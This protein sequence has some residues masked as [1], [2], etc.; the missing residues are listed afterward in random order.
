[1]KQDKFKN[2]LLIVL[3]SAFVYK[4][5]I[6]LNILNDNTPDSLTTTSK[7]ILFETNTI[8][9][10][11]HPSCK[12]C[13]NAMKFIDTINQPNLKKIYINTNTPSG[14]T[15]YKKAIVL[16]KESN[17]TIGVPI[18][19]YE[20]NILVGFDSQETTGQK[21]LGWINNPSK[22]NKNTTQSNKKI[23]SEQSNSIQASKPK[24]ELNFKQQTKRVE[25]PLIG[26]I[27]IDNISLPLLAILLGLADGF[28][29]CAMWVLIYLIS[30]MPG[31]NNRRKMIYI[32]GTFI[33]ASG[34]LYFL[35]MTAWLNIFLFIGYTKILS[36]LIAL[37]AIWFGCNN[38]Y[39]LI[40]N[41]G[42]A[43]CKVDDFYSKQKSKNKINNIVN[44]PVS[45][46]TF[47][48]LIGLAFTVNAIE[49]VCSSGLPAIFTH[50]L[51]LNNLSLIT[52][53]LYI[54]LYIFAFI[55]DDIIVFGFAIFAVNKILDT[56]YAS[57]CKA[58]GGLI[59]IL[60]G[61]W[62]LFTQ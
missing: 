54:L 34:I 28:N 13:N 12:H 41:K 25:L 60:L 23:K 51:I 14:M 42:V 52:Y 48:A 2:I 15:Q 39:E 57:Y 8:Y 35:F 36:T 58:I 9:V 6:P 33:L 19:I 10:Y 46:L 50:Y 62:M 45:L 59:L 30:L 44:A 43:V 47:F 40:I 37:I 16:V 61:L 27:S 53:Y 31:V 24:E 5:F 20:K 22:K 3:I 56:K 26:N 49:F 38:I 21:I 18:I 1:M 17:Q 29:P 7:Q 55:L 11:Y 32:T 4:I